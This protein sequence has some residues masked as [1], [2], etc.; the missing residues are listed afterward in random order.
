MAALQPFW[1]GTGGIG[2]LAW[3]TAWIGGHYIPGLVTVSW[4]RP[5]QRRLEEKEIKGADGTR[6]TDQG[7]RLAELIVRTE[8]YTA[9]QWEEMQYVLPLIWTPKQGGERTPLTIMHPLPNVSGIND[10]TV[11]SPKINQPQNQIMVVEIK[12]L[13]YRPNP[14]VV[15]KAVGRG[16]PPPN[17]EIAP[18]LY[19]AGIA[20]HVP[21]EN[22]NDAV[23]RANKMTKEVDNTLN[24]RF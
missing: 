24:Q 7:T 2:D 23:K 15:K 21:A 3:E 9:S 4:T 6:V 12:C 18:G 10:I 8:I 1:D 11:K 5:P 17:P 13:E 19:V 14:V 20:E 16:N 22:S